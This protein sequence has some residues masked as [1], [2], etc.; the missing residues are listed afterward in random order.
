MCNQKFDDTESL[1]EHRGKE[2]K[3]PVGI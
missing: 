1:E 2:H 3:G